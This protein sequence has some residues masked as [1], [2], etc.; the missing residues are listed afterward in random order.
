MY[1]LLEPSSA[2]LSLRENIKKGVF[3]EGLADRTVTSAK[4]AYEVS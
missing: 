1:D 2:G 3:V 4:D